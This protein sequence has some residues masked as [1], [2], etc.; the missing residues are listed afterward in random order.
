MTQPWPK[1]AWHNLNLYMCDTTL[2]YRYTTD[3]L[4]LN[5][6]DATLTYICMTQP[7]PTDALHDLDLKYALYTIDLFMHNMCGPWSEYVWYCF[8]LNMHKITLTFNARTSVC[9]P[10]M[11]K[12]GHCNI[13]M[14]HDKRQNMWHDLDLSTWHQPD[15]SAYYHGCITFTT[16]VFIAP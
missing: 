6:H 10:V 5:M 2:I 11:C 9:P 12:T 3:D 1:Y 7:W 4:D 15:T 13:A 14:R 16:T 8:G